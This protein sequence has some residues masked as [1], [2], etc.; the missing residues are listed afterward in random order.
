MLDQGVLAGNA[1]IGCTVL[2]VGGRVGGAHDDQAHVIAV[3]TD[4][5]FTRGLRVVGGGDPG[6]GKQR[7]GLFENSAL[8]KGK[9][10]AVQDDDLS[11]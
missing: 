8:R 10:N 2:H 9:R 4:D 1:Q 7:Q 11:A 5:E 3:G 6:G